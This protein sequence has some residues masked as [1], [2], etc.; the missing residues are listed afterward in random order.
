MLAGVSAAKSRPAQQPLYTP[1]RE[2]ATPLVNSR[3]ARYASCM[4]NRRAF[5]D[6]WLAARHYYGLTDTHDD[7]EHGA[8]CQRCWGPYICTCDEGGQY[9]EAVTTWEHYS[10]ESTR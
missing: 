2:H 10:K 3:P 7:S 6:G 5:I 1:C 4:N 9:R 8:E